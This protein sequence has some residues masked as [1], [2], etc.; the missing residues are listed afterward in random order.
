MASTPWTGGKRTG[1]RNTEPVSPY[2]AR[3]VD[4]DKKMKVFKAAITPLDLKY[5]GIDNADYQLATFAFLAFQHMET[6]GMDSVFYFMKDGVEYNLMT[7][8]PLFDIS[9]IEKATSQMTDPFD[10]ENLKWSKQFLF[11]SLSLKQQLKLAKRMKKSTNGPLLWMNIVFEN[12]SDSFRAIQAV[13]QELEAMALS[14]YPGENVKLCT[15]DIALKCHRLEAADSLPKDVGAT[16]CNILTQCSVEAFRIPF[17]AKFCEL[18]KKP[19]CYSYEDLIDDAEALYLSLTSANKWLPK[20][21]E[22]ET[23][24]TGLVAKVDRL[25]HQHH[26]GGQGQAQNGH[27]KG[28]KGGKGQGAQPSDLTCWNCGKKGHVSSK[29][30]EKN[31]D[32]PKEA[33]DVSAWKKKPPMKG[34]ANEKTVEGQKWKWCGRCTRWTLSHLTAEHKDKVKDEAATTPASNLASVHQAPVVS[35]GPVSNLLFHGI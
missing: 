35:Q 7:H 13:Q 18:D 5:D 26:K 32:K 19:D 2:C 3:P 11:D 27:G 12:Q 24:L 33:I 16:V 28:R 14:K 6:Y 30:P 9:D 22:E 8:F 15:K 10:V 23:V 29:C 21:S 17:H 34:E 4:P 20:S 25:I 31:V 1:N